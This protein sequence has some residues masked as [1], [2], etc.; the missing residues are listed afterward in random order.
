MVDH[1]TQDSVACLEIAD[2]ALARRV[3]ARR[4]GFANRHPGLGGMV[5]RRV[6]AG[7]AVHHPAIHRVDLACDQVRRVHRDHTQGGL[8]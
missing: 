1:P 4:V 8:D 3:L 2:R 7:T 6:A 5:N